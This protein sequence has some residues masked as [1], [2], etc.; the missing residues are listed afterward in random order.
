MRP[1]EKRIV[2]LDGRIPSIYFP[3]GRAE[4]GG[5]CDFATAE[6]LENCPSCQVTNPHEQRA[7]QAFQTL[8]ADAL[9]KWIRED[10]EALEEYSLDILQWFAWGDCPMTMTRLVAQVMKHLSGGGRDLV[11]YGF[12]RN[13]E[14]WR[15]A[16]H[17]PR[18][19]L[20]MSVDSSQLAWQLSKQGGLVCHPDF[21]RSMARLYWDGHRVAECS[22]WWCSWI[23]PTG[24]KEHRESICEDC[25]AAKRGCFYEEDRA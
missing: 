17:L 8:S 21:E 12:T 5:S 20:G 4:D 9:V 23:D 10:L 24:R 16:L 22:G 18:V 14:L 19:R 6:C 2:F 1:V 13:I 15:A 3:T 11:Q 25:I 7:F